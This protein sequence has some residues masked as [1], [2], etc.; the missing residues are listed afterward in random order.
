MKHFFVVLLAFLLTALV[1]EAQNDTPSDAV[2]SDMSGDVRMK[3]GDCASWRSISH[4]TTF[5]S[6]D[7]IYIG[8]GA[9]LNITYPKFKTSVALNE[10]MIF[11]IDHRPPLFTKMS[12]NF[13]GVNM[14]PLMQPK[15]SQAKKENQKQKPKPDGSFS[16]DASELVITRPIQ[17]MNFSYPPLDFK[18]RATKYPATFSAALEKQFQGQAIWGY[19]WKKGD[20]QRPIWTGRSKGQFYEVKVPKRGDYV[21]QAVTEDDAFASAPITIS[22][23]SIGT[24]LIP[25]IVSSDLTILVQ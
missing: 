21:F 18:I 19:L 24:D 8:K 11:S 25:K 3:C 12:R 14:D 22:A 6:G 17:R 4:P 5:L 23:E 2:S 9:K 13:N 15:F 7:L 16:T 1:A 20:D 10:S